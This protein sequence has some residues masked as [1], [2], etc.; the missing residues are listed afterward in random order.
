MGWGKLYCEVHASRAAESPG[1]N[2]KFAGAV[3]RYILTLGW[4]CGSG[5][6]VRLVVVA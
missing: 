4:E 6:V 2:Y 3:Y 1:D 5:M